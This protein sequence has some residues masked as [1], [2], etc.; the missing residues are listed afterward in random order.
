MEKGSLPATIFYQIDG[1]SENTAKIVL[2]MCELVVARRLCMK[3]VIT[4]LPV[5]PSYEMIFFMT[6]INSTM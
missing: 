6:I 4:R 2:G 3:I 5:V 1:G